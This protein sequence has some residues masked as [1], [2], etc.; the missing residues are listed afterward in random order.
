MYIHDDDELSRLSEELINKAAE[1]GITLML[2][3]IADNGK[4]L[5]DD[6][7]AMH[8]SSIGALNIANKHYVPMYADYASDLMTIMDE[9]EAEKVLEQHI[10][11]LEKIFWKTLE[12]VKRTSN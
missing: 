4:E 10:G 11:V 6:E 12:E 7:R 3:G 8:Y 5:G 9:D 1:K 2:V